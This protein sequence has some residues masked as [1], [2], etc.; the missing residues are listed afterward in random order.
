M[1][2]REFR[3]CLKIDRTVLDIWIEQGWLVP[4]RAPEG[5]RFH[6]AEVARGQLILDLTRNM[7][8]NEAGVD[9]VMDLLDQIHGLRG[10]MR[11]LVA[12]IEQQEDE[13]KSRLLQVLRDAEERSAR[14]R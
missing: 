1:D 12:A 5:R 14:Y 11:A 7:G 4:E 13:T 6:E 3:L 10:T 9:I 2:D 8:V